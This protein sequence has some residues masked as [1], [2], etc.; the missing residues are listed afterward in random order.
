MLF[1]KIPPI[2]INCNIIQREY[3]LTTFNDLV[4][5]KSIEFQKIGWTCNHFDRLTRFA[6]SR[7]SSRSFF[8][9]VSLSCHVTVHTISRLSQPLVRPVES[10][11]RLGL[12]LQGLQNS[13]QFSLPHLHPPAQIS[14]QSWDVTFGSELPELSLEPNFSIS[15]L[16]PHCS[17]CRYCFMSASQWLLGRPLYSNTHEL[18]RPSLPALPHSYTYNSTDF[19]GPKWI[20][21]LTFLQLI[22]T[23][24]PKATEHIKNTHI[25]LIQSHRF[26]NVIVYRHG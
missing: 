26:W 16:L 19:D 3:L 13:P 18:G 4:A 12:S 14:Q 20:T 15:H 25:P 11:G 17:I 21:R 2:S 1:T 24:M 23:P 8:L 6:I 10:L 9:K 7:W 22:M 5:M